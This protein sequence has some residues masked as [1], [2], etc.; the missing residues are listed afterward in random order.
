VFLAE[1]LLMYLPEGAPQQLMHLSSGLMASG[2]VLAGDCTYNF[3]ENIPR[4][5]EFN[6][7]MAKNGT[8]ITWDLD[9]LEQLE[10]ML[11]N[12][13][14]ELTRVGDTYKSQEGKEEGMLNSWDEM[15]G[16][17]IV[18]CETGEVRET[19]ESSSQ[20]MLII[21]CAM[22]SNLITSTGVLLF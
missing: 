7:L 1:G 19:P 10:H 18:Y 2:S 11:A 20:F 22:T 12:S 9:K 13:G 3:Y 4:L 6:E 16:G 8:K 21:V 14:L 17:Y 15:Q 5:E